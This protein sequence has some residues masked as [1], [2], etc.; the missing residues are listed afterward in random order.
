MLMRF[1]LFLCL[2]CVQPI[3]NS[4]ESLKNIHDAEYYSRFSMWPSMHNAAAARIWRYRRDT[5]EQKE[6]KPS[7]EIGQS[8][9][10][11]V[12]QKQDSVVTKP[13]TAVPAESATNTSTKIDVVKPNKPVNGTESGKVFIWF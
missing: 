13:P 11:G 2:I 5:P 10:G 8:E 1:I 9:G 7:T 3:E 12:V 6:V 4:Y